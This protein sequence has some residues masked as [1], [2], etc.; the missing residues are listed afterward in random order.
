MGAADKHHSE[1]LN[2]FD[3]FIVK[4]EV[5]FRVYALL[6]INNLSIHYP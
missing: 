1:K 5:S 2:D 6:S 3:F 4:S